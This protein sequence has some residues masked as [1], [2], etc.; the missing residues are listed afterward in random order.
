MCKHT[1]QFTDDGVL[2]RYAPLVKRIACHLKDRLPASVQLD[3]LVQNGL[4]GLYEAYARF[5]A[6][7]GAQFVTYGK[8][9]VR[10]AMLD[11]LR[12]NDW[13][14]QHARRDSRRIEAAISKLEQKNGRAPREKELADSLDLTLGE[15]QKMAQAALGHELM[16]LEDMASEDGG[17][18]LENHFIDDA[19]DPSRL[20]EEH[21]LHQLLALGLAAL[22]ERGKRLMTLYYKQDLT[23]RE[24]G[25]LMSVTESR[26]CQLHNQIVMRLRACL[27]GGTGST[28][29]K[30]KSPNQR[31]R[32]QA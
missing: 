10:G 16:Y 12:E 1:V 30:T 2:D 24:I 4:M 14:P 23:F 11:G 18:F 31:Q 32:R 3:D 7:M 26:V 22:P 27:L 20:L 9:R 28:I 17:G 15:Y 13:L 29:K 5:D 25:E 6:G 8:H 21:R 19:N